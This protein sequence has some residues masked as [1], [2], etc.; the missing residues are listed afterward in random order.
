MYLWANTDTSPGNCPW[1]KER[2]LEE[3][4]F[5][6]HVCRLNDPVWNNHATVY[7]A[8]SLLSKRFEILHI[9]VPQV[10]ISENY[11]DD[12]LCVL[13]YSEK[14]SIKSLNLKII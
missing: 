10:P 8:L 3:Y 6:V 4:V 9:F 12:K 5:T 7:I 13:S 14:L 2:G 1:E 11:S